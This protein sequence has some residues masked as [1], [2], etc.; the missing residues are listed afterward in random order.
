MEY[1]ETNGINYDIETKDIIEK[2]KKWDSEFGIIPIGIGFDY[3]EAQIKTQTL[4]TKN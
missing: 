2:Y 4:T 1:A 3:C